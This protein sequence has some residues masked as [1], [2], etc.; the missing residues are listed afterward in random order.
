M[1]EEPDNFEAAVAK[2]RRKHGIRDDDSVLQMLEL[3]KIFFQNVKIE[4]PPDTDSIQLVTIRVSLQTLTQLTKEFSKEARELTQEI[5]NVPQ[6]SRQ[7]SAGRAVAFLCVAV[8]S[9]L[10][11]ILIGKFLL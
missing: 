8:A 9:L 5:R 7:L 3:L 1:N 6:V 10:A 11:G 2:W 4:I